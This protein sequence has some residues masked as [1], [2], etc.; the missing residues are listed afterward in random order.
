M[1]V[2]HKVKDFGIW[3]KGYEAHLPKR[4]EA[5]LTQRYLLRGA[6][7]ENEVVVLFEA[8]NLERAKTFAGS[9]DLKQA[10][11][12]LGVVGKPE[13]HFLKN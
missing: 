3:K 12:K 2:R 8:K 6:A 13:I 10:M 11:Q 9:E 4:V 7:D 5:G 1:L